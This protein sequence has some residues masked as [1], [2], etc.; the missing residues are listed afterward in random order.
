MRRIA[1]GIAVLLCILSCVFPRVVWAGDVYRV[2]GISNLRAETYEKKVVLTWTASVKKNVGRVFGDTKVTVWRGPNEYN[3]KKVAVLDAPRKTGDVTMTWTD[4]SGLIADREYVYKVSS[5]DAAWRWKTVNVVVSDRPEEQAD[6]YG[7]ETDTNSEPIR[8]TGGLFERAIA[9][10]INSLVTV[11]Q[12]LEKAITGGDFKTLGQLLFTPG[13]LDDLMNPEPLTSWWP[14][15]NVWYAGMGSV[16][17][18]LCLI[19]IFLTA[20]KFVNAGVTGKPDVRAEASESMLRWV[21]AVL[22]IAGAPILVRILLLINSALVASL[23]GIAQNADASSTLDNLKAGGDVIQS[24]R[25]GSVLGTA[26]VKLMFAGLELH[27]N[28]VFLV[29]K[30]VLAAIYIFTPIAAWLWAINKNARAAMVWVGEVLTNA[31]LQSAYVIA[32]LLVLTFCDISAKGVKDGGWFTLLVGCMCVLP[33]A[34]MLRNSLQGLWTQWS[35]VDEEGVGTRMLGMLGLAGVASLPRIG[36]VSMQSSSMP[37]SGSAGAAGAD[38]AAAGALD[39]IPLTGAP[40]DGGAVPV[41]AGDEMVRTPSGLYV[42]PGASSLLSQQTAAPSTDRSSP[43]DG[44]GRALDTGRTVGAAAGAVAGALATVAAAAIPGGQI[45]ARGAANVTASL[46]RFAGSATHLGAQTARKFRETGSLKEAV[47]HVGGGWTPLA[48]AGKMAALTG[49]DAVS[50]QM[51]TRVA[52]MAGTPLQEGNS[53]QKRYH[54]P[55]PTS[56]IDG[57]RFH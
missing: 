17:A 47:Q 32:F 8:D 12:T 10:V 24:I 18:G 38:A 15:L 2:S 23:V 29:R 37:S 57:F 26:L 19:T 45:L 5:G 36:A 25:T 39:G 35:G 21:F 46:A 28:I 1:T 44:I 22:F 34:G 33:I 27:L 52:E 16:A 43:G 54:N 49:I 3:L 6:Q 14:K 42:P 55:G 4:T 53:I 40:M 50:P 9:A 41:M 13:D 30:W 7:D 56:S 48:T 51:T 20:F 11:V 31:F